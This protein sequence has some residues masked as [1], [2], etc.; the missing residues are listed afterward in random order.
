LATQSYGVAYAM[1]LI[2]PSATVDIFGDRKSLAT[3]ELSQRLWRIMTIFFAR[4][5]VGHLKNGGI[6]ELRAIFS[7]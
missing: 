5:S 2:E 1:K 4:I 7:N 6:N 3:I